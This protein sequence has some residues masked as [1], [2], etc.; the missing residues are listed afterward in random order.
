MR[1][2]Y[3]IYHLI[4]S[5]LILLSIGFTLL[6]QGLY[7]HTHHLCDGSI[8][9]HAHPFKKNQE[10]TTSSNHTHTENSLF[11]I[12]LW[13]KIL[14]NLVFVVL[15]FTLLLKAKKTLYQAFKLT[16]SSVDLHQQFA[17][18]APPVFISI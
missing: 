1:Q 11:T 4:V 2:K 3:R 10:D 5:G 15:F 16:Y 9:V 6:N 12:D 8:V 7:S 17:G 13:N 18:R 14:S